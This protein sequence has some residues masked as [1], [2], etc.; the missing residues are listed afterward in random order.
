M[1]AISS[2]SPHSILHTSIYHLPPNSGNS[3]EQHQTLENQK[4]PMYSY[5]SNEY[6]L[7]KVEMDLTRFDESVSLF[8]WLCMLAVHATVQEFH[9]YK[10]LSDN[11]TLDQE[12]VNIPYDLQKD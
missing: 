6:M 7:A 5:M 9:N 3:L 12:D 11:R 1:D 8:L 10:H 4:Q 2:H